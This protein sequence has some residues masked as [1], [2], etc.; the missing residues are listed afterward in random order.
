MPLG[1][2]QACGDQHPAVLEDLLLLE[3]VGRR[4]LLVGRF[5][6]VPV[7]VVVAHRAVLVVIGDRLVARL[8]GL[9]LREMRMIPPDILRE[10]CLQSVLIPAL[11]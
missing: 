4:M 3:Q 2:A 5:G 11:Y 7:L 8:L 6:H 9:D 10:S 1:V